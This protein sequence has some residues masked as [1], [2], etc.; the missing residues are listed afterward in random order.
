MAGSQFPRARPA[1]TPAMRTPKLPPIDPA[2]VHVFH[3]SPHTLADLQRTPI[4]SVCGN[5]KTH[6]V[7]DLRPVDE[8]AA[9][10]DAR[11]LGESGE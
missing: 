10:I 8:Q 3:W 9:V 6:R 11:K 5:P 1:K 7:H 2:A 4:C